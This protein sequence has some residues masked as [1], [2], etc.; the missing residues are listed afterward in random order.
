[1]PQPS[2]A[3]FPWL[4]RMLGL[5]CLLAAAVT[6]AACDRCGDFLPSGQWQSGACH[7]DAPRPQ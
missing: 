7:S 2:A 1:M 4:V 3:E 6:L 5:F